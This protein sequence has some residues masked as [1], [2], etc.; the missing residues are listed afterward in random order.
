MDR[1]QFYGDHAVLFWRGDLVSTSTLKKDV[2]KWE[3]DGSR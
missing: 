2:F 1:L 3:E